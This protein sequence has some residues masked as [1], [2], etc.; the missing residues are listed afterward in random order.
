MRKAGV[1]RLLYQAGAFSGD[2]K[3][4]HVLE[5]ATA[6]IAEQYGLTAMVNDNDAVTAFLVLEADD[7]DWT[8][9]RPGM[10]AEEHSRGEAVIAEAPSAGTVAYVDLATV[11]LSILLDKGVSKATTPF[12]DYKK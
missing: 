1:K 8:V 2:G 9:T 6:A 10:L 7:L 4:P 5:G 11:S 3:E 12:I